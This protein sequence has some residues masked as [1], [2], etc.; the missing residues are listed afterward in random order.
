MDST[1]FNADTVQRLTG[2]TYRQL[3]YWDRTGLVR[4]S[5][6]GAQGKGS[7]RVYSF[8]DVVE[9]RV[10]SRMLASGVALPTVR[11]AVR[12]LTQHFEHVVRP[13]AQL[14]LVA[15]G[16][17]VLV[18]MED[19]RHM[20]DATAGGQVVIAVAVAE[21]AE[22]IKNTVVELS[23]PREITFKLRGRSFRAVLTPDLEAGGF[24]VEVPAL[25]GLITEADSIAEAR[26]LVRD[27]A[28]LW[29]DAQEDARPK[30]RAGR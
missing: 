6:R 23:S 22:E 7:R 8:Q 24:T 15:D 14:T 1:G 10:V 3:D 26:R 18:K 5:I 11:K 29:L 9:V 20:V 28:G 12:Y 16:K 17:R 27:A 2:I 30:T 4:P 25:P 19:R 21:I 13:L